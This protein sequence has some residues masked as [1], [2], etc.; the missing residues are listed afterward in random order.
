MSHR[1]L[2]IVDLLDESASRFPGR[3]ALRDAHTADSFADLATRA[4]AIAGLL[5][6]RGVRQ[7]DRV[8]VLAPTGL[9]YAAAYYGAMRSGAIAVPLSPAARATEVNA[10]LAHCAA[11]AVLL[12]PEYPESRAVRDEATSNRCE[13]IDTDEW[14]SATASTSAR[15][16]TRPGP[17]DPA[18]ILYTSGTTGHPKGVVLSHRGLATNTRAIIRAL[19]LGP[20]DSCLTGL[21]FNYSF[22]SSILHTHV[23]VGATLHLAPSIVFPSRVLDALCDRRPTGFYGVPSTYAML[24]SRTDPRTVDT[25]SLRYVAHAGAAMTPTLQRRVRAAFPTAD[26][27]VMYG[28]TE[29]SARLTVLPPMRLDEKVGSVGPAVD[30]V[31]LSVRREGGEPVAAGETGDIWVRGESV[32]LGYWRD[33]GATSAVIR[34]G[35]LKTGDVGYLDSEGFLFI[36]GRR[37]DIIKSGAHRIH[38]LEIERVLLETAPVAEACVVGQDD[39]LMGQLVIAFVVPK[40]GERIDPETL[41]QHCRRRLSSVKVPAEIRVVDRLPKTAS[42]KI[43]RAELASEGRP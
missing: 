40:G 30:G 8:V 29:A 13:I 15:A 26:L 14:A 10:S 42:G 11:R 19:S 34:H 23:A 33:P 32:M 36:V 41:R 31:E 2:T 12:D 21:P 39:E 28:Q 3:V 18:C 17:D 37:A 25:S 22:G 1:P 4:N 24:L 16:P 35:W 6:A 38:P 7:G 20:T 43:R 5:A 9:A 27:I